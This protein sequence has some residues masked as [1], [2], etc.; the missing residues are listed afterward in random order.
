M[1]ITWDSNKAESNR[2]KHG[3]SFSDVEE[4]F[5]D[6]YSISAEDPDAI[7]EPRFIITGADSL[8]R[9][10]TIVYSY[11]FQNIRII[12]ARR[13]TRAEVIEYERRIRL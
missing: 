5:M 7:K 9:L 11:R 4:V 12:S 2:R 6:P 1:Q 13:A 3:V 8:K 10:T